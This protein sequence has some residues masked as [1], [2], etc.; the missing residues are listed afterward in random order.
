MY[1]NIGLNS[2]GMMVIE[3]AETLEIKNV[4]SPL[5]NDGEI[6][7][8]SSKHFSQKGLTRLLSPSYTDN[9]GWVYTEN[10]IN[11]NG[12]PGGCG[13]WFEEELFKKIEDLGTRLLAKRIELNIEIQRLNND[14]KIMNSELSKIEYALK[15]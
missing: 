1:R 8:T 9:R 3:H 4:K 14:I 13:A 6:V 7:S 12:I 11:E 2:N 5:F 10:Y 15:I